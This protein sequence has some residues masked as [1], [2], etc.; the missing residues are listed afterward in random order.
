MSGKEHVDYIKLQVESGS[1]HTYRDSEKNLKRI[2]GKDRK[3]INRTRIHRAVN[4]AGNILAKNFGKDV[5]ETLSASQEQ[6]ECAESSSLSISDNE[7]I[8]AEKLHVTVDG[9]HVHG[10][11]EK[12]KNFEVMMGKIYRPE[13]LVRVDKYHNKITKK[14]CAASSKYDRQKAM[15]AHLID[16]ARKEGID[17]NITEVTALADGAKNCWNILEAL[18]PFCLTIIFILDWFHIGKYI[19]NIKRSVPEFLVVFE[20][21]REMLWHGNVETALFLL[22]NLLKVAMDTEHIRLIDNFYNYINDN[23]DHIV[24]YDDRRKNSLIFSSHVAESTVEHLLNK[25]AKKKQKMQWSRTGIHHVMQIRCSQ[26]GGDWDD[27]WD[28]AITVKLK[29]AA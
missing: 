11:E 4:K 25:R 9:G 20:K 16:A 24:N 27:D 6:E 14:H 28:N 29:E 3:S 15:K 19:Q 22:K 2:L 12:G 17:K 7:P 26:V 23:R 1:N 5:K 10:R 13:N 18:K 21:T 8:P